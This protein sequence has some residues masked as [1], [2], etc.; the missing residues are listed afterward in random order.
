MDNTTA[1]PDPDAEA[2]IG[3]PDLIIR[4]AQLGDLEAVEEILA[5]AFDEE[6]GSRNCSAR[7]G[8]T[9]SPTKIAATKTVKLV[10]TIEGPRR[11]P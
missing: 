1:R 2:P 4:P 9:I 11:K 3:A 5:Q 7:G 6:Y 10:M 8:T